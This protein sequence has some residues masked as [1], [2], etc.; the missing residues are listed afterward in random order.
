MQKLFTY[1]G[2]AVLFASALFLV[3]ILSIHSSAL[4]GEAAKEG[5]VV[6]IDYVGKLQDDSVFDKSEGRGPLKFT[7]GSKNIIPGM[8]DGVIGMKVGDNKTVTIP[9]DQAY[10]VRNEK[11][12]FEAPMKNMPPG[13]KAGSK[14]TNPQGQIITVKEVKKDS[15]VL[16]ANHFLAGETLIFEIKMVS[17]N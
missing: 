5:S 3:A 10:G 8:S 2:R 17:V 15:A 14:L 16:D 1:K 7:V 11:L 4:A 13:I 6:E 12:I 9:P